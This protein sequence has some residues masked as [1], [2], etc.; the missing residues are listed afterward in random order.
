MSIKYSCKKNLTS[1]M[2]GSLSLFA[3]LLTVFYAN[4]MVLRMDSHVKL[5]CKVTIITRIKIVQTYLI[6]YLP[7]SPTKLIIF[8]LSL[9][10]ES[11]AGIGA[12]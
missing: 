3:N 9:S 6:T 4:R 12:D 5:S 7:V 11:R 2:L 1:A 10:A 8:M